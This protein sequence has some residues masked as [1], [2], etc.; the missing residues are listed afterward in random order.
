[1]VSDQ[2]GNDNGNPSFRTTTSP[3]G[4]WGPAAK[5]GEHPETSTEKT[6]T[7]RKRV[8]GAKNPEERSAGNYRTKVDRTYGESVNQ[9]ADTEGERKNKSWQREAKIAKRTSA[10]LQKYPN[11]PRKIKKC[12]VR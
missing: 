12:G 11:N 8:V 2:V 6:G 10:K 1:M 5:M 9:T 7:G 4:G 3:A